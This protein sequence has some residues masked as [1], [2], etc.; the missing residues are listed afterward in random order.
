MVTERQVHSDE[1]RRKSRVLLDEV[2]HGG[3]HVTILRW[4]TPAAVMVPVGW[5]REALAALEATSKGES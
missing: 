3:A 1:M 2:E 5:H 4:N